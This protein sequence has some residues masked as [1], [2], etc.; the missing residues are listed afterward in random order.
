[1][2]QKHEL[3]KVISGDGKVRFGADIQAIALTLKEKKEQYRRL[4]SE[5]RASHRKTLLPFS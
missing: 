3:Q 4:K 2:V 1:M 5:S